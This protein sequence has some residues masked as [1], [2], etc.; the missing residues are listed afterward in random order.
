MEFACFK[1]GKKV[2][3]MANTPLG[4][5]D[6]CDHCKA[7]LRV[8]K[9]CRHYEALAKWECR[10]SISESVRDK[11]RG[12]F[13]DFFQVREGSGATPGFKAPTSRDDLMKA[14]EALFKKK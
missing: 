12:N 3:R 4:R 5:S 14:A 8:C 2:V 10:E 9:N 11:E 6:E 1:C 7:D 13:C